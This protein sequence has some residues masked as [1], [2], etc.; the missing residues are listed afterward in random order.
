MLPKLES[1]QVYILSIA[2][3][4]AVGFSLRVLCM[5]QSLFG[6]EL[7]T[8]GH[9]TFGGLDGVFS[10][11][12]VALGHGT[13]EKVEIWRQQNGFLP[14]PDELNPPA[15]FVLAWIFSELSS[16]DTGIR[17][18]SLI[19]G[20]ATIPLTILLG[21]EL[22][23]WRVGTYAGALVAVSPLLIFQSVEARPYALATFA[24]LIS[25]YA[26]VRGV[27]SREGYGWWVLYSLSAAAALYTQYVSVFILSAQFA[28]AF[29]LKRDHWRPLIA[30]NLATALLLVPLATTVRD[31]ISSPW[32][33]ALS[34]LFP[35]SLENLI[36]TPLQW[37]T[38]NPMIPAQPWVILAIVGL[39]IALSIPGWIKPDE[40][41][42]ERKES[43]SGNASLVILIAFAAPVGALLAAI[44]GADM[45]FSARN[46]TSSWPGL[47]L[48]IAMVVATPRSRLSS[49]GA[50]L[51]LGAMTTLGLLSLSPEDRRP[52]FKGAAAYA[53]RFANSGSV[54]FELGWFH[55][56]KFLPRQCKSYSPSGALCHQFDRPQRLYQGCDK[57][58]LTACLKP[59]GNGKIIVIDEFNGSHEV[60]RTRLPGNF[61]LTRS[62]LFEGCM[63]IVVSVY[64]PT[65]SG[66]RKL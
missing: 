20:I 62:K 10:S 9:V 65:S 12:K 28:W 56:S 49:V 23:S 58:Q 66:S 32:V 60:P 33:D 15:Y 5:S 40:D 25:N 31:D 59:T 11:M 43:S 8:F 24:I 51:V 18:P 48:L 27:S 55:D 6:D 37:A 36:K 39:G 52:D 3:V 38:A 1:R 61:R 64:R 21:K 35:L 34:I 16:P 17:L 57:Q 29:W 50:L 45:T 63:N 47:A 44:I 4:L 42:L 7:W 53:E 54:I 22:F 19:A 41:N 2:G 46:F 13:Q 14:P 30:S 26:L